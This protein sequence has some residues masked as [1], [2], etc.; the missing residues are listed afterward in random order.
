MLRFSLRKAMQLPTAPM[1]ATP[2]PFPG[3]YPTRVGIRV[4]R[5][6]RR[7][8]L[9]VWEYVGKPNGV[10]AK[11]FEWMLGRAGVQSVQWLEWDRAWRIVQASAGWQ[12]P[13]SRG[14]VA[15]MVPQRVVSEWLWRVYHP[16]H[17]ISA[18]LVQRWM[19]ERFWVHRVNG[20]GGKSVRVY[21]N[22]E[23]VPMSLLAEYRRNVDVAQQQ[24]RKEER[25]FT[26]ADYANAER[27]VLATPEAPAEGAT[28]PAIR[29][30]RVILQRVRGPRYAWARPHRPLPAD[31]GDI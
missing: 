30:G 25:K 3:K 20:I 27:R 21:A 18:V 16:W 17:S 9:E 8:K 6:G 31:E 28:V 1:W 23:Q 11:K 13:G 7:G 24:P 19:K 29:P 22:A 15:N 10:V 26:Y 14:S 12:L 4:E 2:A 5:K